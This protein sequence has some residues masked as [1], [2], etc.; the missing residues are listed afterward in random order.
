MSNMNVTSAASKT[1]WSPLPAAC[2]SL[3]GAWWKDVW[4]VLPLWLLS[5]GRRHYHLRGKCTTSN[6]S[7][8]LEVSVPLFVHLSSCLTIFQEYWLF[9]SV[10][11]VWMLLKKKKIELQENCIV[12]GIYN[13]D[14]RFALFHKLQN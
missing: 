11:K 2:P 13:I 1:I 5:E 12:A 3:L 9:E 4:C 14:L 7:P 6:G 10:T 8:T